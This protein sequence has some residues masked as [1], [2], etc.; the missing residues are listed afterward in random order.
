MSSNDHYNWI[1]SWSRSLK[2]VGAVSLLW[3]VVSDKEFKTLFL[4]S[5]HEI[6]NELDFSSRVLFQLLSIKSEMFE[7]EVIHVG[8]VQR[9]VALSVRLRRP[10]LPHIHRRDGSGNRQVF[11]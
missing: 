10:C 7:L 2:N 6:I 8:I 11:G 4:D 1:R 5:I 9:I 3:S